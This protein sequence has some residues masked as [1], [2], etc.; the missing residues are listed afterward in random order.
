MKVSKPV[1]LAAVAA[2]VTAV[3]ISLPV[4]AAPTPAQKRLA[5][6]ANDDEVFRKEQA[7]Q[8]RRNAAQDREAKGPR[9]QRDEFTRLCKLKPVMTDPEIESCK[10]AYKL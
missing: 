5:A 8:A 4:F 2:L 10:K 9:H 6:M 1:V 7:D 3:I